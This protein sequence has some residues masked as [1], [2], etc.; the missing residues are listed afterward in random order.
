M[1]GKA[2][3]GRRRQAEDPDPAHPDTTPGLRI[4]GRHGGV[5][6][7][8]LTTVIDPMDLLS[9]P[10]SDGDL[11][12]AL[13]RRPRFK[14]PS[15]TMILMIVAVASLGFLGG[16]LLGKH[17]GSSGGSGTGAFRGFAGAGAAP[18]AGASGTS[19]SS[20]FA[21][22]GGTG[23]FGGGGTF[24]TIK[25]VDGNIVYV[26]TATGDIVQVST[27]AATK[28]TISSSAPVKDLLPGETVIVQGSKNANGSIAATSISQNSLGAGGGG[29]GGG[30]ISIGGGSGG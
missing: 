8:A 11:T 3:L 7:Q 26:Q 20:G 27:S 23:L 15:L 5:G 21:G 18:S 12:V 1:I 25:L 10:V 28:V 9:T 29:G 17:Y 22:R 16:I 2:M 6:T 4:R 24:G 30:A 13:A 14:V 19:S